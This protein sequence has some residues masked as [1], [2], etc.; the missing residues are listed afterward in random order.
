MRCSWP[1][2][3]LKWLL[4]H[5]SEAPM[6]RSFSSHSFAVAFVATI[7]SA[8]GCSQDTHGVPASTGAAGGAGTMSA[9]TAGSSASAGTTG[10]AG[11]DAAGVSGGAAGSAAPGS[12]TAGSGTAG[13][14]AAGTSGG[15]AGTTA[16]TDGGVATGGT[17][18]AAG[19]TAAGGRPSGMS[20]GCSKIPAESGGMTALHTLGSRKYYTTLP[21]PFDPAVPYPVIFYGQ[22]CG[23]SGP[24]SGVFSGAP[25][26]AETIYAQLIP[27]GGCFEA[28][29]QGTANSPDGT[30]F[31]QALADLEA[32]Y[33]I[34]KGKVYV[35]GW[36][37]GAWLSTYLACT[38]GNVIRGIATV[39]GGLQ[40][41]HATCLGGVPAI[42]I[43]GTGD[44]E[45]PVVDMVN[46]FDVGTGQ[47]RDLLIKANGCST[48]PM[49]W[50][51]AYPTCQIYGGCDNPVI[52]CPVPGGH[53]AGM[54]I[55][56][57]SA[58]KFWMSL[59]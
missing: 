21:K 44:G 35:S 47:A 27:S 5:R 13:S 51:S 16:S 3:L 2:F 42:M 7:V 19:M 45:N 50:D 11:V 41:D 55:Q 8:W 49:P 48:T 37:S 14:A 15:A 38:R 22:G 58:W 57:A 9:G 59:K 40:H 39:A 17:S 34:D 28:G 4:P 43:I 24:E 33:C 53:G 25:Y 1:C 29:K 31:D 32:N 23:Q 30:Y 6:T 18:G 52:W 54:N 56:A 46:G 10:A 26:N 12:G 36:S 20:A